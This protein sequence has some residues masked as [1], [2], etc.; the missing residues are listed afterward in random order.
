MVVV[1]FEGAGTDEM[2]GSYLSSSY[3][4]GYDG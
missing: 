1:M 4:F 3:D 2:L